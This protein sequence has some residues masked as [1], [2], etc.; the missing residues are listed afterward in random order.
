MWGK[1]IYWQRLLQIVSSAPPRPSENKQILFCATIIFV[2]SLQDYITSTK[3]KSS[4]T[5]VD[6]IMVEGFKEVQADSS[7]RRRSV[8]GPPL[9][10]PQISENWPCSSETT[11]SFVTAV[12]C[13]QL[14]HSN[15]ILQLDF[16]QIIMNLPI[17]SWI[18][19]FVMDLYIYLG[20]NDEMTSLLN[21]ATTRGISTLEANIRYLS[22]MINQNN[23][24]VQTME[25]IIASFASL[26]V[27]VGSYIQNLTATTNSRHL[28]LLPLTRRGILQYCV[29]I[30]VTALKPK[31]FLNPSCSNTIIGNML[32]LFQLDWPSEVVT[33]ELIFDKIK[34]RGSFTY[35]LFSKYMINI[36]FI[37][38]FMH[39]WFPQNGGIQL[40]FVSPQPTVGTRRIG[41]RGA[42]KGVK[43]DFKQ[44]MRQQ[45]SRSNE[46]IDNLII[47][48]ITQER[49][50]LIQNIFEK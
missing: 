3:Y 29:K 27:T 9:E 49:G 30:I 25:L 24:N 44:I 32:V 42:D 20:R 14:L 10:T 35:M 17:T 7:K 31:I 37:E 34:T 6:L 45:I 18:S 22:L 26:P 1:D 39:L 48:F 12:S 19:R 21:D 5:E 41:T 2:L 46:D 15:E 28:V 43:D 36:D 38:E 4:N 50:S 40:E 16:T 47:E 13:W 11:T 8:V 33:A 23:V